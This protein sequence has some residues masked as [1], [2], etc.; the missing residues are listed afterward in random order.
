MKQL[1][2]NS[3]SLVINPVTFGGYEGGECGQSVFVTLELFINLFKFFKN[4][5]SEN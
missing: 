2:G 5:F 3:N 4:K 1:I